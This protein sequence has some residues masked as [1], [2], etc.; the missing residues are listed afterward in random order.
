[1]KNKLAVVFS[2]LVLCF[3]C[4][5]SNKNISVVETTTSVA[6]LTTGSTTTSV[7][8]ATQPNSRVVD[9]SVSVGEDDGAKFNVAL[10]AS[11]RITIVNE[12]EDDEFHL[13]GYD[14]GGDEI[15]AGEETVFEFTADISGNFELESHISGDLIATIIVK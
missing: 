6:N 1:V 5:S 8:S 3:G 2:S 7:S 12:E 14:L 11:V 10:G 4:S 9:I 13:H 15:S